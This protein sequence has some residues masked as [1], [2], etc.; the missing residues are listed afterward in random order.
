MGK[1]GVTALFHTDL[2]LTELKEP[3]SASECDGY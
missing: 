1:L 2:I 3:P